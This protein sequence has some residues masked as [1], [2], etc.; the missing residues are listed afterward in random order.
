[1]KVKI[2]QPLGSLITLVIVTELMGLL[3]YLTVREAVLA[4]NLPALPVAPF[5]STSSSDSPKEKSSSNSNETP[6]QPVSGPPPRDWDGLSRI[7]VLVLGLDRREGEQTPPRTDTLIVLSLDPRRLSASI[8]SLPGNL[9]VNIPGF[10][11]YLLH[12]AYYIGEYTHAPGG[13]AGLAMHTVEWL[14]GQPIDYYVSVDFRAFERLIDEIGGVEMDVATPIEI[15]PLGTKPRLVLEAGPQLLTGELALAY[16]RALDP[17]GN[18]FGRPQ[19]QAQLMLGIRN[20]LLEA[21][22]LP[23]LIE[24]ASAL[25]DEVSAGVQSNLTLM[26]V[27]RMAWVGS[28][29]PEENIQQG[30]IDEGQAT[31]LTFPDGQTLL[32]PIPSE[33]RSLSDQL[34]TPQGVI[35]PSAGDDVAEMTAAEAAQVAIFN[36]TAT[37]G[38]ASRTAEELQLQG[39]LVS[40]FGNA[41]KRYEHTTLVDYTGNPNTVRYLLD[42]L[43]ISAEQFYLRYDPTSPVD[44]ALFLGDDWGQD[45]LSP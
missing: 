26:Q 15:D 23:T 27:I 36:G 31:S 29:L 28:Q 16:L 22:M 17:E 20:R 35:L 34:L 10:D 37:P 4:R 25:Y 40:E 21:E 42:L 5:S 6:L 19:R 24:K 13:G 2:P 44:L 43:G 33:I 30:V 41:S 9:W 14:L 12:S 39:I 38:L 32:K 11:P 1:M 3:T 7:N 45:S 8:L 18:D